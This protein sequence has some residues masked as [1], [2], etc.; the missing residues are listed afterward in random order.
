[1]QPQPLQAGLYNERRAGWQ[2]TSAITV[3]GE[4]IGL[5]NVVK[6]DGRAE[7]PTC[8]PNCFNI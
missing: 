2:I 1:M 7:D 5:E 8:M 4:D 3:K 6:G